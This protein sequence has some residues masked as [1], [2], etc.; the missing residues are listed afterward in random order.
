MSTSATLKLIAAAGLPSTPEVQ[1]QV[2]REVLPQLQ[3][4]LRDSEVDPDVRRRVTPDVAFEVV[5]WWLRQPEGYTADQ[6]FDAPNTSYFDYKAQMFTFLKPTTRWSPVGLLAPTNPD[7]SLALAAWSDVGR[8]LLAQLAAGNVTGRLRWGEYQR[9]DWTNPDTG[10]TDPD[11]QWATAGGVP[12]YGIN[13]AFLVAATPGRTSP[14]VPEG[15]LYAADTLFRGPWEPATIHGLATPGLPRTGFVL[16]TGT[17]TGTTALANPAYFYALHAAFPN[18]YTLSVQ[19]N[20]STIHFKGADG[21]QAVLMGASWWLYNPVATCRG[22][23]RSVTRKQAEQQESAE[24]QAAADVAKR[25]HNARLLSDPEYRK[26]V[27]LGRLIDRKSKWRPWLTKNLP[28]F[29]Y[30]HFVGWTGP[31]GAIPEFAIYKK[32]T[33]DTH[34]ETFKVTG[35]GDALYLLTNG[36]PYEDELPAKLLERLPQAEL[37][38]LRV[39]DEPVPEPVYESAFN[40]LA[41]KR[42]FKL[43]V[44][45]ELLDRLTDAE[46]VEADRL[47]FL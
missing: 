33:S 13:S 26:A 47:G 31:G 27:D 24:V 1:E 23:R 11:Y 40:E 44:S 35:Y 46:R 43:S 42:L 21:K 18:G 10:S 2:Y 25:E 9:P 20:G 8:R 4:A 30:L 7:Y 22:L 15:A 6:P 36:V 3:T 12:Y 29:L 34:R 41:N 45:Q 16:V 14:A 28:L 17:T 19:T 39:H 38:K 32:R 5:D 37:A